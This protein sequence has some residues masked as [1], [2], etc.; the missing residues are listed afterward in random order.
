IAQMTS[1]D[2]VEP[3]AGH[4]AVAPGTPTQSAAPAAPAA[5]PEP[6]QAPAENVQRRALAAPATPAKTTTLDEVKAKEAGASSVEAWVARIRELRARG[7]REAAAKE[8]AAFRAAYGER[9]SELL[10]PDLRDN[11]AP[12]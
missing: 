12:K 7:E 10:P 8:L 4:Q 3:L 5:M 2:E 1:R 6:A 9:A 11:A